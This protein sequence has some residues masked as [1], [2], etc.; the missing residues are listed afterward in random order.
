LLLD[1]RE[2]RLDEEPAVETRDR[3]LE[4]ERLEQHGHA[5]RRPAAGDG[6]AD[7]GGVQGADGLLRSLGQYFLLVDERAV[8]VREYE[9]DFLPLRHQDLA[10]G[11]SSGRQA[12]PSRAINSAAAA[13]P[14]LPAT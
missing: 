2:I 9:R 5:A 3:S 13:G 7:A 4:M 11:Q 8:D 10:R 6:E 12:R 14:L 1:N